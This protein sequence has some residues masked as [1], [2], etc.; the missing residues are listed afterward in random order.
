[1]RPTDNT[2]YFWDELGKIPRYKINKPIFLHH[3][4]SIAALLNIIKTGTFRLTKIDYLNDSSETQRF[5]DY[6]DSFLQYY[7]QEQYLKSYPGFEE[8]QEKGE[9][10]PTY[11]VQKEFLKTFKQEAKNVY[12]GSFTFLHDDLSQW[13]G[14]GSSAS[15]CKIS[16]GTEWLYKII[17]SNYVVEHL[18]GKFFLLPCNY[19]ADFSAGSE[20]FKLTSDYH[21]YILIKNSGPKYDWK[22]ILD[23]WIEFT[24]DTSPMFKDNAFHAEKEWRIVYFPTDEA[25]KNLKYREG[26]SGVIPYFDLKLFDVPFQKNELIHESDFKVIV[27]HFSQTGFIVRST[28]T[29]VCE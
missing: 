7:L 22:K 2:K 29:K 18:P 11:K 4:T 16:F 9:V 14:Y 21:G 10:N 1:M 23:M 24:I 28:K 25:M 15:S 17:N 3:Y 26:Q 20:L 27:G 6:I 13:R 5:A 8:A 19:Y 12:I